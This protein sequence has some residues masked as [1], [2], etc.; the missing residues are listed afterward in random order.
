MGRN[1][2][3]T[4]MRKYQCIATFADLRA[5]GFFQKLGFKAQTA[6]D[7]STFGIKE[8][9]GVIEHCKKS[10]FMVYETEEWSVLGEIDQIKRKV[11]NIRQLF[12]S[13]DPSQR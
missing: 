1:L 4:L 7:S 11:F 13:S 2:V 3:E 8:I 10:R 9:L 12:L 6:K 5:I